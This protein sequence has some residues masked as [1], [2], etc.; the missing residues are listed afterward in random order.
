VNWYRRAAEQGNATAQYNLASAY[1]NGRGVL[2]D[3]EQAARWY[4]RAAEQG[5]A[6]AQYNLA[7]MY[8]EGQGVSRDDVQAYKWF[9]IVAAGG[10]NDARLGRDAIARAMSPAQIS[11]GQRLSR[12]WLRRH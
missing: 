10:G 3:K 5:V 7:I 1:D 2:Q 9:S 8:H 11:E 6:D 12:E 4:K